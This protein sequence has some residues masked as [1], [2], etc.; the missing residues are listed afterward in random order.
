[1][2]GRVY[3]AMAGR[4]NFPWPMSTAHLP[5]NSRAVRF[6][7]SQLGAGR[8]LQPSPVDMQEATEQVT[9]QDGKGYR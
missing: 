7:A 8:I 3:Q 6:V 4:L 5:W 1:M 9:L 2:A